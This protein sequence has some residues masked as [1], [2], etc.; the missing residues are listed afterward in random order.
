MSSTSETATLRSHLA[1]NEKHIQHL[2][3]LI[4]SSSNPATAAAAEVGTQTTPATED[5]D[6]S[7]DFDESA[8]SPVF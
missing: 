8:G 3:S 1:E 7:I 2:L 5:S 6:A 4:P